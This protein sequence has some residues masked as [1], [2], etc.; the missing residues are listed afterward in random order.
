MP[1]ITVADFTADEALFFESAEAIVSGRT[2]DTIPDG[3]WNEGV[4]ALVSWL[5]AG[6]RSRIITSYG[7]AGSEGSELR[8]M[9]ALKARSSDPLA[10]SGAADLVRPWLKSGAAIC[11]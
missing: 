7:S 4:K 1:K 8:P 2:L 11:T 3:P 5:A 9:A 6:R 10:A